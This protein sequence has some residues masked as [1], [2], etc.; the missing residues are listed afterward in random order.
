MKKLLLACLAVAVLAPAASAAPGTCVT[1]TDQTGDVDLVPTATQP[2]MA[3]LVAARVVASRKGITATFTVAGAP[4]PQ[5]YEYL[6]YFVE[7]T[8]REA[9]YQL[10]VDLGRGSAPEYYLSMRKEQVESG[11]SGST[12]WTDHDATG[13]LDVARKTATVTVSPKLVGQIKE[14]RRWT[15]VKIVSLF[16]R[17]A[18]VHNAD[19]IETLLPAALV[20]GDGRCK[21]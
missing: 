20:A 19:R 3:D 6:R 10:T 13:A 11:G 7:L 4:E 21:R 16:G 8:D 18:V 15:V 1:R 12:S 2:P 14:G 5:V 9:T 17:V